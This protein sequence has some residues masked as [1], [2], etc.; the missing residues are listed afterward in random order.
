MRSKTQVGSENFAS[1]FKGN[2][3]NFKKTLYDNDEAGKG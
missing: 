1:F 3:S 2:L